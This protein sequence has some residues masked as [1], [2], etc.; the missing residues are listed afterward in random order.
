[1][2]ASC[3]VV[4]IRGG[5]RVSYAPIDFA[6]DRFTITISEIVG[7]VFVDACAI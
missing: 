5:L 3:H 1:M 4:A 2:T 7:Q 6:V